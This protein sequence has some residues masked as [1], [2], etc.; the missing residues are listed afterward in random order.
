MLLVVIGGVMIGIVINCLFWYCIFGPPEKPKIPA[1]G[2]GGKGWK[3]KN[4]FGVLGG[5]GKQAAPSLK[6]KGGKGEAEA[7]P[8]KE[9]EEE[10]EMTFMQSASMKIMKTYS[11]LF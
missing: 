3:G 11:E 4:G 2:C 9:E 6:G 10:D 5:K 1:H 7:K 8:K